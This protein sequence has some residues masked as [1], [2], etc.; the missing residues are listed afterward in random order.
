MRSGSRWMSMIVC[1]VAAGSAG[2]AWSQVAPGSRP[3]LV[4][5]FTSEGC[6]SC[7]PADALLRELQGR[8]TGQGE[9]IVALSEHVTYWNRLGWTDP[10]SQEKFTGRQQEYGQRFHLE[11]VYTPQV[12]VNGAH[13]VLGSDRGAILRAVDA[14]GKASPVAVELL[15]VERD[16]GAISFSYRVREDGKT[17]SAAV[18][19]VVSED[20]VSSDVARG[21]NS[22]RTLTHVA[23]ARVLSRVGSVHGADIVRHGQ[24]S[25]SE[26]SKPEH[27]LLFAQEDGQGRILSLDGRAIPVGAEASGRG[28]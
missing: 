1:V 24:V 17:P 5:L 18:F 28:R 4:E 6:S 27:L 7:P 10:Y 2:S 25:A 22:G 26:T 21:E 20:A 13:E 11:S 15:S 23:V 14:E 9:R 19:A 16:G 12:I 8:D 3:V